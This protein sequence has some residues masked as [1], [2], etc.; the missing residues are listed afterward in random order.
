MTW[1]ELVILWQ[2][3]DIMLAGLVTTAEIVLCSAAFASA[4]GL[5]LFIGLI[6]RF[7]IL[8]S[9][10]AWLNDIVRC[11]PFMLVCYLIYFA[12]PNVGIFVGSMETGV[13]AL[14]LYNAVYLAVLL[15]GAWK[16]LPHEITEAGVAFGFQGWGLVRMVLPPVVFSAI[17]VIGNQMIQI[18]KDSAFLLIIT[19]KELTYA[20]NAIQSTYYIPLA[21][22]LLAM[23]FYWLLCLG[24]EGGVRALLRLAQARR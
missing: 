4:L 24:V 15:H 16:E 8:A 14:T 11:V 10:L 12:L 20:A 3:R 22:F 1:R 21:S 5:V 23:V 17:P 6:S 19:V 9:G 7:R 13:L 18:I 2:Q